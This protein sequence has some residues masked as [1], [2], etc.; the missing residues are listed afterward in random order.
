ML[1]RLVFIVMFCLLHM[2]V[3]AQTRK[4]AHRSHSGSPSTFALML[5]DDH[6]G[7][8]DPTWRHE[9][10]D[11]EPWIA[12][13]RKHY[14]GQAKKVDQMESRVDPAPAIE[15]HDSLP[16]RESVPARIPTKSKA[17]NKKSPAAQIQPVD[18]E[19]ANN[20]GPIVRFPLARKPSQTASKSGEA[21]WWLGIGLFVVVGCAVGLREMLL[22]RAV[23][24][25][26]P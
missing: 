26:R 15:K 18:Q 4:L 20:S 24:D 23:K 1:R 17:K 11:L 16:I 14:E 7:A 10:Y 25:E 19:P 6:A 2:F 8:F 9:N 12:K 5:E 22:Q 13:I 3:G 21:L